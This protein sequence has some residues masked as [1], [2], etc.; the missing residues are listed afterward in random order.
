M[1]RLPSLSDLCYLTLI[2]HL[3]GRLWET[4]HFLWELEYY[5]DSMR[6]IYDEFPATR[7]TATID[8]TNI[9]DDPDLSSPP[10]SPIVPA[11]PAERSHAPAFTGATDGYDPDPGEFGGS[12]MAGPYSLRLHPRT[13]L[14]PRP[15]DYE[16]RTL[17]N[18]FGWIRTYP[19]GTVLDLDGR[20]DYRENLC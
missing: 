3:E 2:L 6:H 11:L 8:L 15:L 4:L 5:F 7:E 12:P 16:E 18:E 13:L 17:R 19:D 1:G 10:T 14:M 20:R 9:T